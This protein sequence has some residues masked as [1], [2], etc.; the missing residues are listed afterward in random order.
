MLASSDLATSGGRLVGADVEL[1]QAWVLMAIYEFM[2]TYHHEACISSGR[3]FRLVQLMGLNEVDSRAGELITDQEDFITMEEKRRVFWIA[4]TFET[5]CSMRNNLPLV[6]NE[7]MV[8][9]V[10]LRLPFFPWRNADRRT[11]LDLPDAASARTKLPERS[12]HKKLLP[13]GLHGQKRPANQVAT[14]RM[15][16]AG[17][18]V[19]EDPLTCTAA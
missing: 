1:A 9:L 17:C 12:A 16:H 4:Y 5:L 7:H 19:R 13:Q 18:H 6:I 3:A 15:H 10:R 14:E 11:T 2:K 8:S